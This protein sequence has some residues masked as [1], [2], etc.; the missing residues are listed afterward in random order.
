MK[1]SLLSV[2]VAALSC[3]ALPAC[4]DGGGSGDASPD[5]DTDADSD[6]DTDADTDTDVDTEPQGDYWEDGYCGDY[7]SDP[8][9]PASHDC[10]GLG[11][12]GC[13]ADDGKILYCDNDL[14]WCLDCTTQP[15][16]HCGW[17]A[18]WEYY[19][20]VGEETGEDP[21]GT[22]PIDCPTAPDPD[23]GMD[24]GK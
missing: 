4:D 24:A 20:C 13:C 19:W 23:G 18:D 15:D 8:P 10:N 21:W 1:R 16:P 7:E 11:N 17:M 6:S 12:E 22:F 2:L 3:S 5:A 14:L 9:I